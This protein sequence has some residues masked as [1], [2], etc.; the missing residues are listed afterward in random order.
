MGG[1]TK[2]VLP[3]K[4]RH[5]PR[6]KEFNSFL[7]NPQN[8]I[9]LQAFLKSHFVPRRKQMNKKIYLSWK[10]QLSGHFVWLAKKFSCKLLSSLK[11]CYNYVVLVFQDKG[12]YQTT[13]VLIDLEKDTDAVVITAYAASIFNGKLAVW[14]KL[15][16]KGPLL[17]IM[18]KI[19]I[20]LNVT[21]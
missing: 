6:I 15:Q 21:T 5:F 9:S 18:S 11:S 16:C 17:K 7:Q 20:P 2:N 12:Y 13:T 3:A 14:R 8:K 10:K 19:T 1:Q 4:E